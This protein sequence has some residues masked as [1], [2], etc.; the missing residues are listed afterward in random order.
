MGFDTIA[1]QTIMFIAVL[2]V[3]SMVVMVF[4]NYIYET[5][6]TLTAKK[7]SIVEKMNT[8]FEIVNAFYN[9]TLNITSVYVLN[10]GKTTLKPQ[11]LEVFLD[12]QYVPRENWNAT[13]LT[14]VTN[15][16]LWDPKEMLEINISMPLSNGTHAVDIVSFN[17]IKDTYLFS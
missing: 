4:N 9:S 7:N 17:G 2:T 8:E 3:A 12:S 6:A 5:S 14:S 10:T 16:E 13:I 15:P 11:E 1:S